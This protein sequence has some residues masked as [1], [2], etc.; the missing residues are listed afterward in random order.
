MRNRN[1]DT[2]AYDEIANYVQSMTLT[3]STGNSNISKELNLI[4]NA[5]GEVSYEVKLRDVTTNEH[6]SNPY[7]T[8][9]NA[10]EVY[11]AATY[12]DNL[13]TM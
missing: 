7:S 13:K 5:T 9:K 1:Y 2:V 12:L 6:E 3:R 10:V 4:V 8:L 11:N